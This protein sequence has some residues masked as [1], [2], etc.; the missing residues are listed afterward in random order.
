MSSTPLCGH[1]E[2]Q[3]Q[4]LNLLLSNYGLNHEYGDKQRC[5]GGMIMTILIT[6]VFTGVLGSCLFVAQ[7]PSTDD[8]FNKQ[9]RSFETVFNFKYH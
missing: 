6:P 7:V 5:P 3:A 4:S 1:L 8:I 2:I 9:N